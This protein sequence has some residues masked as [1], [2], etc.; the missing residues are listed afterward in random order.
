MIALVDGFI[1]ALKIVVGS[2]DRKTRPFSRK[3]LHDVQ[4]HEFNG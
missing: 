3:I 2:A 1:A 4:Y